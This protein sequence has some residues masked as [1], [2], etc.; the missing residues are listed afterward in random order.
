MGRGRNQQELE[1]SQN[2]E[3]PA[4]RRD[5]ATG[6]AK[7]FEL[8]PALDDA[9]RDEVYRVRHEVYCHDLGW[10][11]VRADGRESDEFDR[12][13]LH[14]VLRRR[15][16]GDPV[17]CVRLILVRPEDPSLPLPFESGC[18]ASLDRSI[19]D[20]ARLPRHTIGE[21]SRLAVVGAYRKREGESETALP[22]G[23]ADF[24]GAKAA[25]SRFPFIPVSLYLGAASMAHRLGVEHVFVLTEP[26]LASHF[27][28]IGFDIR[29]VGGAIE[30]RGLRV[31]S[32]LSSSKVVTRLRPLIRPMYEVIDASI[33]GGFAAHPELLTRPF[34]PL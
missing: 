30:H 13:S 16:T 5:L 32:V 28:R 21:V 9:T 19:I 2:M 10:E 23:E 15:D 3:P 1:G 20:P 22:L 26:R 31:P 4:R 24:G 25:E 7:L 33:A 18:Q 34:A 29:Q 11:P 6:F 14:C 27:T 17:G 8:L 12:H